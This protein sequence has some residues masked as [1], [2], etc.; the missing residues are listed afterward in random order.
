MVRKSNHNMKRKSFF[1]RYVDYLKDNPKNYWFRAKLYGWGWTPATWQGWA[2]TLLFLAYVIS[3][4][5]GLSGH[6][7]TPLELKFFFGKLIVAII[8][9]VIIGSLTGERPRWRW[10]LK[11]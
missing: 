8:I 9:I 10:G 7:P 5:V 2:V 1:K 4:A 3:L 6:D 11:R